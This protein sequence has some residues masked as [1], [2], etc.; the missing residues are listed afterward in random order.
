M[1]GR[2]GAAARIVE[3]AAAQLRAHG[4]AGMAIHAV[5]DAAAVSKGLVH[6]HFADKDALCAA[7]TDA[8][9]RRLAD[10]AADPLAAATPATVVDDVWRWL[11]AELAAGD[12]AALLTLA[13]EP[14]PRTRGA[15]AAVATARRAHATA[16]LTRAYTVLGAAPR[17]PVALLAEAFTACVDGL[18]VDAGVRAG[19][20]S[21]AAFEAWMLGLLAL[22]ED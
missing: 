19:A 7:V 2:P 22:G 14:T 5:A 3:A 21:R 18:V 11:A 15:L 4:A 8:L 10:R 12:V 1:S 17:V 6:Y 20:D 9:G 16:L 13:Q